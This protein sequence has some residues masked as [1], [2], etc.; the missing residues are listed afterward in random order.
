M[1]DAGVLNLFLF[2]PL[3]GIA[4]LVA[5]PARNAALVRTLSLAVSV[6]QF[7]LIAWLYVRFDSRVAGLQFETRLPWIAA[8]GV[9]YQIGLDGY[10]VLLVLLT[11][12]LG[13]LVVAGAFTAITKDVKLFYAMVFAVQFA[14]PGNFLAQHLFLFYVLWES[15]MI[16][17][18]FLIG[19]W[20][21]AR[22]L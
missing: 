3:L 17:M 19:T 5:V 15:M 9:S 21:G 20:G 16:P 8:W 7:A 1:S 2:L 18:L 11:G 12:F 6:V 14:M 4:L 10:N 13:P 22:P